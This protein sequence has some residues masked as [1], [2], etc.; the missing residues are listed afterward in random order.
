MYLGTC[1]GIDVHLVEFSQINRIDNVLF[2]DERT[3]KLF[4]KGWEIG[5]LNKNRTAF[6]AFDEDKFYNIQKYGSPA[7]GSEKP[8]K[9]ESIKKKQEV[10]ETANSISDVDKVLSSALLDREV[11]GIPVYVGKRRELGVLDDSVFMDFDKR[12]EE[13]LRGLKNAV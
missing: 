12:I 6:D 3:H 5:R 7:K 4:Y 10:K 2:V 9:K 11:N 1:R 8:V 13:I